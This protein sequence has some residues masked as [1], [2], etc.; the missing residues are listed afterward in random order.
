[1]EGAVRSTN[2]NPVR[3]IRRVRQPRGFVC[4][5]LA[6]TTPPT[7]S[8]HRL[9]RPFLAGGVIASAQRGVTGPL[10]GPCPYL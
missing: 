8:A 6:D 9:A 4:G 10:L 5:G 1:M 2:F 3:A 7:A